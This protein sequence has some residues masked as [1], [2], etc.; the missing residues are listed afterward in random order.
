MALEGAD[1][2]NTDGNPPTPPGGAA[3]GERSPDRE[4]RGIVLKV[5]PALEDQFWKDCPVEP[6]CVIE[7]PTSRQ[8]EGREEKSRLAVFV[9]A[10]SIAEHGA[11][12][13]V[14]F[15]GGAHKWSREEG[16]KAFSRERR[17]VHVCRVSTVECEEPGHKAWHVEE[18]A[19]MPP[20]MAPPDYV[21][22]V[23]RKEWQ[24]RYE[25]VVQSLKGRRGGGQAVASEAGPP[26]APPGR[27]SALRSRLQSRAAPPPG[28]GRG[29]IAA[30]AAL[31]KVPDPGSSRQAWSDSDRPP[32]QTGVGRG[33]QFRLPPGQPVESTSLH[34]DCAG[35]GRVASGSRG[36]PRQKIAGSEAPEEPVPAK[37]RPPTVRSPQ[38]PHSTL[39]APHSGLHFTLYTF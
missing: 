37:K 19:V 29:N 36:A 27:I 23:K 8:E 11:W 7:S 13:D 17:R 35:R 33:D 12:L 2:W 10:I 6:G 39:Y 32:H 4:G 3:G 18:V 20:G 22:K 21:E 5:H 15:L 16:I 30:S 1:P 24:K 9:E 34:E 28:E 25:E 26:P 14:K 38:G 31:Q